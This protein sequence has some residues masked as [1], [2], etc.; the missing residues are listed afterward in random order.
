MKAVVLDG[1]PNLPGLV[2][3]SVYDTKPDHFLL[4]CYNTIKWVQKTRQ[5]YDPKI[6]VVHG[7]H[8][9][10]LNINHLYNHNIDLIDLSDQLRNLYQVYHRMRKYKWW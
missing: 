2:S 7:A 5:V 4:M 6:D 3:V 1:V 10:L 8:F 9:F